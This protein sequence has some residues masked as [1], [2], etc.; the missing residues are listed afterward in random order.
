MKVYNQHLSNANHENIYL[1]D[2]DRHHQSFH[3]TKQSLKYYDKFQL[4]EHKQ[5]LHY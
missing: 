5:I 4:K 3:K 2:L 1:K